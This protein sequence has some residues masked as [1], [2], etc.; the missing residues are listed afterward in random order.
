MYQSLLLISTLDNAETGAYLLENNN[1][2]VI[3]I[4][5]IMHNTG[6]HHNSLALIGLPK[7]VMHQT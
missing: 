6:I 4:G 3:L 1:K 2:N 5:A 7:N